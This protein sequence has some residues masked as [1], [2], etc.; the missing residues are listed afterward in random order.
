MHLPAKE[1]PDVARK[2]LEAGSEA[3]HFSSRTFRTTQPCQLPD[4]G[5]LAFTTLSQVLLFKPAVC[6]PLLPQ[7]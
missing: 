6:G 2:L 7:P 3:E 1:W 4:L 5:C